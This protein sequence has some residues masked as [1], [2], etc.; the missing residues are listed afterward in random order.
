M[1]RKQVVDLVG[2]KEP[3]HPWLIPGR[4]SYKSFRPTKLAVVFDPDKA[5]VAAWSKSFDPKLKAAKNKAEIDAVMKEMGP[6]T[7]EFETDKVIFV[8]VFQNVADCE[9]LRTIFPDAL[10]FIQETYAIRPPRKV[11]KYEEEISEEESVACLG[12]SRH[13]SFLSDDGYFLDLEAA[14]A[15]KGENGFTIMLSYSHSQKAQFSAEDY[16]RTKSNL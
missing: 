14:G 3:W 16:E 15:V 12:E 1:S 7:P 9:E 8:N 4:I 2:P 13:L 6:S 11:R 5:K 10:E